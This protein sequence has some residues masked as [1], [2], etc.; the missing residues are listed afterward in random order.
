M[1]HVIDLDIVNVIV[2]PVF[3]ICGVVV[4]HGKTATMLLIVMSEDRL[5]VSP[6]SQPR[7]ASPPRHN[8]KIIN[9]TINTDSQQLLNKK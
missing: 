9:I 4:P 1:F 3:S 5:G 2:T 6:L 8:V 7:A